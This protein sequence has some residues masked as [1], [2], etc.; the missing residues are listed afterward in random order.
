MFFH[1]PFTD[2]ENKHLNASNSCCNDLQEHKKN[3]NSQ[4]VL[5]SAYQNQT[6]HPPGQVT[7]LLQV[8]PCEFLVT[9]IDDEFFP[10]PN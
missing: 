2:A 9:Q 4:N 5:L 1:H 3:Q 6:R 8:V 7:N 10:H